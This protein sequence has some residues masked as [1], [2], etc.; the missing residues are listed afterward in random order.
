[1]RFRLAILFAAVFAFVPGRVPAAPVDLTQWF[2]HA[3]SYDAPGR[4]LKL[5]APDFLPGYSLASICRAGQSSEASKHLVTFAAVWGLVA[6][7]RKHRVALATAS[8]DQCSVALFAASKPGIAVPDADLS[9]YGTA[10][11]IRIGSSYAAVRAAYGGPSKTGTHF[12]RSYSAQVADVT[13]SIPHKRVRL[14]ER[15]TLVIDHNRVSAI[16]IYVNASGDF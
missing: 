4:E 16:T 12:V 2:F 10:R 15:I 13:V 9:G 11:G 8:T 6:Y 1:M 7:D 14:P 3:T 5:A